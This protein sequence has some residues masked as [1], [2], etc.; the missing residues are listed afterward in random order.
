[1]WPF[2]LNC[3]GQKRETRVSLIEIENVACAE[4]LFCHLEKKASLLKQSGTKAV[5]PQRCQAPWD[6]YQAILH[7]VHAGVSVWTTLHPFLSLINVNFSL[8]AQ[9]KCYCLCEGF[10]V[11]IRQQYVVILV[12][13]Q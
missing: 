10:P 7:F 9:I 2:E 4:S 13:C 8:K 3:C 1:M 6:K 12:Y 11:K 5:L